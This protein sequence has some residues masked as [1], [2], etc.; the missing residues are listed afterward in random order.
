MLPG[1]HSW[2]AHAKKKI[3][4]LL[5]PKMR[6][7]CNIKGCRTPLHDRT[8]CSAKFSNP[9][10]PGQLRKKQPCLMGT[11]EMLC[12]RKR[13]GVEQ[14]KRRAMSGQSFAFIWCTANENS[15]LLLV[16]DNL[17]RRICH[18]PA[19]CVHF[20]RLCVFTLRELPFIIELGIRLIIVEG[21]FLLFALHVVPEPP[22]HCSCA[23]APGR[24]G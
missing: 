3:R 13:H 1:K 21:T 9:H 4:R 12:S 11:A 22:V 20:R 17:R 5:N 15:C 24:S 2:T 8:G 7:G 6:E 23:A 14:R 10:N 18:W 16:L 19:F